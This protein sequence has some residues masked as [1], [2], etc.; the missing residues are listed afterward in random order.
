MFN[1]VAGLFAVALIIGNTLRPSFISP[2]VHVSVLDFTV[3]MVWLLAFIPL[4][5]SGFKSIS[6]PLVKPILA[7]LAVGF[8]S[9]LVSGSHYGHTAMLVG[10][11][12]LVRWGVYALLFVPVATLLSSS[13]SGRLQRFLGFALVA[14][15]LAQYLL[16]PDIRP[17]A[18][19]NWDPHYFRVVGSLLDPGFTGILL[20]F[21]L[22]G[23]T[24]DLSPF[25]LFYSL[26]WAVAYFTLAFTYSRSSFL[27]FLAGFTTHAVRRKSRRYFLSALILVSLTLILLP[28]TSDGEGVKLER[29]STIEA[30]LIGWGHTLTIFKD[31]PLIGVGFDTYRYAQAAYGYLGVRDWQTSHAGAGADSSLLFVAATTGV[32]GLAAYLWYLLRLWTASRS[33]FAFRAGLVALFF[34]SWFL[35]SQFYPFVM[36]WISLWLVSSGVKSR[37]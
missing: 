2:D 25:P 6:S 8:I 23:Q 33:H 16:V 3:V 32:I 15:C 35:N 11:L 24:G 22:L 1:L 36:V 26:S 30:R 5:K 17:L 20:V 10:F 18:A 7:F 28:R 14:V 19:N 9:L 13:Q 34:H 29:T 27:A 31:H 37:H 12:Y 21:V 4:V